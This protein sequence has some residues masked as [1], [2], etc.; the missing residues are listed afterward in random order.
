MSKWEVQGCEMRHG[1]AELQI[2]LGWVPR[3]TGLKGIELR[4]LMPD[5]AVGF[6][7]APGWHRAVLPAPGHCP[8]CPFQLCVAGTATG[9]EEL[10]FPRTVLEGMMLCPV[11]PHVP[12]IHFH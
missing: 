1:T 5:F 8:G 12:R 4:S 10:C 6:S 11:F 7:L 3:V 9:S 2:I